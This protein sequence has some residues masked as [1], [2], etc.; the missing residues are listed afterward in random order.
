M[1][2]IDKKNT[3][4]IENWGQSKILIH[5]MRIRALEECSS[6][7]SLDHNQDKLGCFF[8]VTCPKYFLIHVQ[9][10]EDDI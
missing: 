8:D 4:F 7:P 5:L 6:F 1:T 9:R 10:G 2:S 3:I